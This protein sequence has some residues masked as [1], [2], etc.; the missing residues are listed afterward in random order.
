VA[1]IKITQYGLSKKAGGWD[2]DG[3]DDTDRWVGDD[4]PISYLSCA[5]TL[6]AQSI[7]GLPPGKSDRARLKIVFPDGTTIFRFWSDRAPE[8]DPRL[9]LFMPYFF[10]RTIPADFAEVSIS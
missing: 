3:D 7:I 9:D 1:K 5:L 4:G 6:G 10:D 8:A 2:P